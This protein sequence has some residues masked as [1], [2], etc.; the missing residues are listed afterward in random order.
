MIIFLAVPGFTEPRTVRVG[1]FN[2]FPA[3]FMDTDGTVKG[4]YVESLDAI[5]RAEN[6]SFEYVWG[7]WNEGLERIK[8]GAVDLLTSVAYT[9]ERAA[10]MDYG[11][12]PLL[13]VWSEVYVPLGSDIDSILALEGKKVAVMKDDFNASNFIELASNFH[14]SVTYIEVASF[15]EVFRVVADKEADGGVVNSTFGVARQREYGIRSTGVVFN[16]FDIYFTAGK[17]KNADIIRLLDKYLEAWKHQKLSVYN[18]ARQKWS[19]GNVGAIEIIPNWLKYGAALLG[20]LVVVSSMFILLLRQRVLKA[21]AEIRQKQELLKESEGRLRSYV[22]SAP[23]GLFVVDS[24]GHYLEAN[25]AAERITGYTIPEL[26]TLSIPDLQPPETVEQDMEIFNAL[27]V[28]GESHDEFKYRHKSGERRWWSLT[29]VQLSPS[30][31]LGF[32]QDITARKE[33]EEKIRLLLSEKEIL[34]KEVHHRIKNNMNTIKGLLY[35]QSEALIH[36]AAYTALKDAENRVQSMIVLYDKL[37]CSDNYREL[38]VKNY[39]ED[40]SVEIISTFPNWEHVTLESKIEDFILNVQF[41]APLGIILNELISNCMKHAFAGMA[42]GII[43][44]SIVRREGLVTFSLADNGRGMGRRK[45]G[46]AGFGLDLVRML[47]EQIGG[48]MKIGTEKETRITITFN[49]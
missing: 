15:D 7:S 49:S 23:F 6:I 4:F 48:T 21:T 16:P 24:E 19:H 20:F 5:G 12:I 3:I 1:A 39:L 17:G 29:G 33:A 32:A 38:S 36:T 2:F 43:S 27:K 34:L 28:K 10:Y 14:L 41:L 26:L 25:P 37:Y 42:Q 45:D 11:T 40:L 22:D 31:Y 44:L 18:Q 35:M 47:A 46:Q 8:S 9:D 30:R 13:T